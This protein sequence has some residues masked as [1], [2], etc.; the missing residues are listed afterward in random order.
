MK[1]YFLITLMLFQ[2]N[3]FAIEGPLSGL[4]S[5]ITKDYYEVFR[6][7][8]LFKEGP[9]N[10]ETFHLLNGETISTK[11]ILKKIYIR[12]AFGESTGGG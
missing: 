4:F 7:D 11:D 10:N 1:K 3:S 8:I 6:E 5:I 2:S 9:S 12:A